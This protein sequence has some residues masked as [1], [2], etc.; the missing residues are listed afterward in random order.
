MRLITH[1]DKSTKAV[2]KMTV[3]LEDRKYSY[4]DIMWLLMDILKEAK[5]KGFVED[6][7]NR[8]ITINF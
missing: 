8:T 6:Q 2:N 5:T 7:A 3:I 4:K 1:R